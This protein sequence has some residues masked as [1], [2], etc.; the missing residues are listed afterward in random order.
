MSGSFVGLLESI[1]VEHLGVDW[2]IGNCA[3]KAFRKAEIL[4]DKI[5]DYYHDLKR[6]H[7]EAPKIVYYELPFDGT[8]DWIFYS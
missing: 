2:M 3:G 4:H 1:R 5:T 8:T 6:A 7:K